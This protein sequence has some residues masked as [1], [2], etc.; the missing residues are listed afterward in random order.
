MN[1]D[2]AV[3]EPVCKILFY[4]L[5]NVRAYIMLWNIS[6]HCTFSTVQTEQAMGAWA[7]VGL[8]RIRQQGINYLWDS[9]YVPWVFFYP[10]GTIRV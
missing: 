6:L 10:F 7:P 3:D 2:G 8:G 9:M 1:C 5:T 4:H